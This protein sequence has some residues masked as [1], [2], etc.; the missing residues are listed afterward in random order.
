MIQ[1]RLAEGLD[2]RVHG[3]Q[4]GFR[5][6]RS[7]DQAVY[8]L[9]RLQDFSE[10]GG[11]PL[12]IAF[13]DWEKAF[14]KVDQKKLVDAIARFGVP[15][16]MI[17]VLRSFYDGPRFRVRD[18]EGKSTYRTQKTGIR[19]GCPL[20]PYLFVLWLTAMFRDVHAET[21]HYVNVGRMDHFPHTEILYADDTMIVGKRA[22]E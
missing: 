1:N 7:T 6:G 17:R 11:A 3:L 18:R 14:D 15:D 19:Q 16:K 9:R 13:L 2:D 5:K 10:S 21:D 22:R 12:V 20:S 4:F 8:L